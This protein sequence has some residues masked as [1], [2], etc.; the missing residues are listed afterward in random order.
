MHR[1]LLPG[2]GPSCVC[3]SLAA[4]AYLQ[5][6]WHSVLAPAGRGQLKVL[7]KS[8]EHFSRRVEASMKHLPCVFK[9]GVSKGIVSTERGI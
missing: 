6:A 7:S 2:A 8:A 4:G 9:H 3:A 5:M 1:L